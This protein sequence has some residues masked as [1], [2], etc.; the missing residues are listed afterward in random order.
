MAKKSTKSGNPRQRGG[1]TPKLTS[2]PRCCNFSDRAATY[3]ATLADPWAIQ[4]ARIPLAPNVPSAV[5][6]ATARGAGAIGTLGGGFVAVAPER[7]ACNDAISVIY[8]TSAYAQA[9]GFINIGPAGTYS[10]SP[11]PTSS[12]GGAINGGLQYRLV[13]AGIRINYTGTELNRG[14]IYLPL[15]LTG[16]SLLDLTLGSLL[17]VPNARPLRITEGPVSVVWC[18]CDPADFDYK[19]APSTDGMFCLGIIVNGV[20]GTTFEY[21]VSANFE[22]FGRNAVNAVAV[23]A[24]T[25]AANAIITAV[26]SHNTAGQM[27]ASMDHLS[28]LQRAASALS[29][30]THFVGDGLETVGG[31][32]LT[33][34]GFDVVKSA[35]SSVPWGALGRNAIKYGKYL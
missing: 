28:V 3:A 30:V 20:A 21:E 14:G 18:A 16:T 10:N 13:S 5:F 6:N 29:D 27:G 32:L 31:A 7:M 2:T 22:V 11:Y 15:C 34:K 26:S 12:F 35:V 33:K 8:T 4:G 9:P 25:E 1:R 23:P 17:G 19:Q 24:D